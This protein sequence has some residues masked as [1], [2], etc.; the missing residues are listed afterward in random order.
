MASVI[1]AASGPAFNPGKG[2]NTNIPE[3]RANTSRNPYS[4]EAWTAALAGIP[5]QIA[6]E[7]NRVCGELF[8]HPR[9]QKQKS[10]QESGQ[11]G[12]G[13]ESRILQRRRDLDNIHD[14]SDCK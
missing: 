9:H 4:K 14:H 8:Q 10:E 11:A 1:L 13:T 12:N 6:K 5:R 3:I 2:R 7:G